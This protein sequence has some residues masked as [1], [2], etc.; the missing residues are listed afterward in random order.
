M[1]EYLFTHSR[2]LDAALEDESVTGQQQRIALFQLLQ[3]AIEHK[4]VGGGIPRRH[5]LQ[6]IRRLEVF[7]EERQLRQ[8]PSAA[9][10]IDAV[11][12][13][14]VH[15]SKGLEFSVVYLPGLG[16]QMFPIKSQPNPCPP[17]AG[18]LSEDPKESHA[19]EE[20]CLFFVAM[21]RARDILHLS[22]ADNYSASRRTSPS[23]LLTDLAAHL[24]RPPDS[25]AGWRDGGPPEAEDDAITH[26][27]PATICTLPKTS[28]NISGA[29]G[30]ISI[31][32]SSISAAPVMTTPMCNFIARPTRCCAGW[33][34]WKPE[35]K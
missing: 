8:M 31:S 20:E 34:V 14:T 6:W 35:R 33:A 10:G 22:R 12:L 17:P 23:S 15:A 32:A 24:P 13:F 4:L 18:M 27:D 7:G 25:T 29:R 26:L 19:E 2:Y 11:R 28:I 21:S 30:P 3:F 5:L 9:A 16:T 1:S